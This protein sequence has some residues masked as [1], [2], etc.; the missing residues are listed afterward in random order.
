MTEKA[1]PAT[2]VAASNPKEVYAKPQPKK[3]V[4]KTKGVE[5]IKPIVPPAKA[6]VE[7]HKKHKM[8]RDSFTMP[9]DDY[10]H[11]AVLKAKCLKAGVAVKKSEVLRAALAWLSSLS[12]DDLVKAI[13][14]LNIIKTGRPAKA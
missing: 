12:D 11:I 9:Q 5:K 8:V 13:R 10:A 1:Q 7:K 2:K 14:A 6:K 4:T 3:V